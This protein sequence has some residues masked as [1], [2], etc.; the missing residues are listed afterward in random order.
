MKRVFA[1]VILF[2]MHGSA[3]GGEVMERL[4]FLLGEW[5]LEYQIPKSSMSEAMT[6]SGQGVM[7]RALHN[8]YITFDYHCSLGGD[9]T[10][11]HGIFRWDESR[12]IYR[13]WWFES[14]GAYDTATC[15]LVDDGTLYMNWHGS[16]LRQTFKKMSDQEVFLLMELPV[17]DG[18]YEL[19]LK[20]I[21]KRMEELSD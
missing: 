2:M 12:Q 6:G 21:M 5:A 4:H 13:Y 19:V 3:G 9:T 11:A 15:K 17:S 1:V 14:S 20:V 10:E 18:S 16:V 8:K 7:R